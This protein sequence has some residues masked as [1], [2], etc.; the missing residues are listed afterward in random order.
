LYQLRNLIF[1]TTK[2]ISKT[3]PITFSF[4]PNSDTDSNSAIFYIY[5]D[6]QN[7]GT[8]DGSL[9][10]QRRNFIDDQK[11]PT[12]L[13]TLFQITTAQGNI[14]TGGTL[15]M[16]SSSASNLACSQPSNIVATYKYR[17]TAIYDDD[18][19]SIG[20]NIKEID[21]YNELSK[22]NYITLS[23]SA[24]DD[25]K[26]Y[27]I[28]REFNGVYYKIGQSLETSFVD[29]NLDLD[30]SKQL[31][32]TTQENNP[33]NNNNHPLSV[34][35][36]NQRTIYGGAI[37]KPQTIFASKIGEYSNF[38]KHFPLLAND[39]IEFEI[40]SLRSQT[41]KHILPLNDIIVFSSGSVWTIR[42][43]Y[44]T[45]SF[46]PFAYRVSEEYIH[47]SSDINPIKIGN[48][49]FYIDDTN[50]DIFAIRYSQQ[51]NS[52]NGGSIIENATH[53]FQYNTI[54]DWSYNPQ[55]KIFWV[56]LDNGLMLSICFII[57]A[58][59]IIYSFAQHTTDGLFQSIET[60]KEGNKYETYFIVERD[61]QRF[62]EKL[63]KTHQTTSIE[64]S[65][66]VDCGIIYEGEPSTTIEGLTHLEGKNV[67]GIADGIYFTATVSEGQIEL[68]NPASKVMVGL[69]YIS[70]IKTMDLKYLSYKT[71][72]NF[73]GNVTVSEVGITAERYHSV[74][75]GDTDEGERLTPNNDGTPNDPITTQDI[76]KTT[77]PPQNSSIKIS[78]TQPFPLYITSITTKFNS[79]KV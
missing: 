38:N 30:F 45:G 44:N 73:F 68:N 52:L 39:S 37:N 1:T 47:A 58:D 32:I 50:Q 54:T 23:W 6:G 53:F 70:Y 49:A 34:A 4:D 17:I 57:M 64:D 14:L 41:I 24:I 26:S 33:F 59:N 12:S 60:C 71:G 20:S 74:Y 7:I 51:T 36:Y 55:D 67:V 18:Q 61:G 31:P 48:M 13:N 78:Q 66:Y 19:E 28:Y 21:A 56:I 8:I 15:H 46:T 77:I 62:L 5:R 22:D 29:T 16:S 42:G 76:V 27:N 9:T 75:F 10:S 2:K 65:F 3:N 40:A 11:T 35:Y 72:T 25:A 43:D 79:T 69:P 63:V